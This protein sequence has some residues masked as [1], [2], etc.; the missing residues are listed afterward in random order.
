M[1]IVVT[2]EEE[3]FLLHFIIK[4]ESPRTYTMLNL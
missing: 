2:E 4:L 3:K 1:E